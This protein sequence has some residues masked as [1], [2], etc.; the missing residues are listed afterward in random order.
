MKTEK[1][2]IFVMFWR[3]GVIILVNLMIMAMLLN[4]GGAKAL[5]K[6]GST[7]SE[8]TQIQQRLQELGYDP[9]TADGIYGTRTK[10]AVI[11][12]Q[13]D[14]GLSDDGIAGP[15][16][17]EALGLSGGGGSGGGNYGGF[18]ESD[19]QLLAKIISAESRGEPYQGQ[20]AVGAVIMNRIAHPSFPNT[21]S[22]VIYQEGAFSCLYDGGVNAAVA[23]SAYQA[24]REAINGS[25]PTGGAI[26][27]YN[28]AKTTNK[29][30]WSRQVVAVIGAHNFAI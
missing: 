18:S 15:K 7:G 9:G 20:V 14:Y 10:N 4:S 23:D 25:D 11:S 6:Y 27:Y 12:F 16:T 17:L 13:R 29:W 28:P 24:A 30:I 2:K 1:K 19:I 22:G 26:Y 5:S 21:L 8:V 3:T